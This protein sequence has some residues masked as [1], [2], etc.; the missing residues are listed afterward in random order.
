MQTVYEI[1]NF[2]LLR[3]FAISKSLRDFDIFVRWRLSRHL[4]KEA[5]RFSGSP[6]LRLMLRVKVDGLIKSVQA[7]AFHYSGLQYYYGIFEIGEWP[8][9]VLC[10]SICSF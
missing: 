4:A 2:S 9:T 6:A 5:S 10:I 8:C 3:S 7:T 1:N